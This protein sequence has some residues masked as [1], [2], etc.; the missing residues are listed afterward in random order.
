MIC[1]PSFDPLMFWSL[2]E[3]K[4]FNWYYAAPTMHQLIL[5][6]K[7]ENNY[8]TNHKLRMIANAAGGLLPSFSKGAQRYLWRRYGMTE[9]MPISSPPCSYQLER[10]GTSGVP[11]GPEV[12]IINVSNNSK[13]PPLSE[14]QICVR[15]FP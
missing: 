2:L 6:T 3:K 5:Q 15:G 1:C 4:K 13:L 8:V 12:S 7:K 10:P 11:I 9:C 14:G